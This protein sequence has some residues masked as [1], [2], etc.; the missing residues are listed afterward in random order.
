MDATNLF[1]QARVTS[2][3]RNYGGGGIKNPDFLRIL[4]VEPGRVL[5]FGLQSSF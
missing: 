5:T 4:G 3:N 1:N 2:R